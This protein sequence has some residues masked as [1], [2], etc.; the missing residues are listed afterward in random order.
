MANLVEIDG[1]WWPGDDTE[2]RRAVIP[3]SGNIPR[4]LE[5]VNDFSACVQAGGNVGLYPKIL[6]ERFAA[7]YSFEPDP[8]NFLCMTKNV[9]EGVVKFNAAL[10]D[11]RGLVDLDLCPGNCGAHQIGG[12]GVIP[13]L[14]IDDLGLQS[15][16][17]IW[18]DIEGYEMPAILGGVQ[19]IASFRPVVAV[20]DKGLSDRYGYRE[21]DCG[22]W[23]AHFGYAE[24]MRI[25]RDIVYSC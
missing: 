7:V 23:L 13:I 1:L 25:G 3:E 22:K 2:C 9:A 8:V 20:E 15:C 16:G 24:R 12:R 11:S 21:G 6:S 10:G 17:L 14:R 19:T 18:L 4:V 5:L